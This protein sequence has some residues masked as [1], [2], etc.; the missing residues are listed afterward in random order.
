MLVSCGIEVICNL[1]GR[2]W[3][4]SNMSDFEKKQMCCVG[5]SLGWFALRHGML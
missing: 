3:R 2:S 5:R 4:Q 1:S